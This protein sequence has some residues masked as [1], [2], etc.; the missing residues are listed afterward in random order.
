MPNN[1]A[2]LKAF[3]VQE[4]Y[5]NLI[6]VN[7]IWYYSIDENLTGNENM[8]RDEEMAQICREDSI[9]RLRFYTWQPWTLSLGHNQD[10]T[11]ID[12]EELARQGY[13]LVTRPTGGRAVFH[14]EEV[15]YGIAMPSNG[16]GIHETY[17][18]ISKALLL[19]L[20]H[21]GVPDIDFSR[22]SPNFREHYASDESA[23]CFSAS[24]LNELTWHGK[25]VVGSAQRRYGN[26]LLQHGSILVDEAH[27]GIVDFLGVAP[28]RRPTLR[29]AL[30][31]RTA[32][33]REALGGELPSYQEICR[34]LLHGFI[35]TFGIEAVETDTGFIPDNAAVTMEVTE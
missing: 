29:A 26:V 18:Q 10:E 12:R 15:T 28:E 21:L 2:I 34:A 20:Q 17:A 4:L 1:Q 32:T 19:G 33:I 13:G 22:S 7:P 35:E 16:I 14:A 8:R 11:S 9:P 24:A 3:A 30:A 23:S 25:K 31:R 6:A 27:L 5:T